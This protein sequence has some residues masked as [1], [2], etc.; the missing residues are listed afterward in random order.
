MAS[1]GTRQCPICFDTVALA[2][3]TEHCNAHFEAQEPQ[4]SVCPV[5]GCSDLPSGELQSHLEAHRL[6]EAE[7]G[8]NISQMRGGMSA[9]PA[10]PQQ[11]RLPPSSPLQ[12][13]PAAFYQMSEDLITL[14][15]QCL[16]HQR[17]GPYTAAV[18]GHVVHYQT[19]PADNGFGCGYR[20]IQMLASHLMKRSQAM[21]GALFGGCGFVPDIA[22]LQALVE[23]AWAAGWDSAGLEQLGRLQG[24][25]TWI[26]TTEA[27]SLFRACGL[28]AEIVDFE[29]GRSQVPVPDAGSSGGPDATS[30]DEVHPGVECDGCG[31]YPIR[32]ACWTGACVDG[33]SYDLCA[34]C[35]SRPAASDKGPF[36]RRQ[37]R[38]QGQENNGPALVK[39]VWQYFTGQQVESEDAMQRLMSN[40]RS[41]VIRSDKPPLFFQHEGHSRTIVGIEL[42]RQPGKQIYNLLV[43]DPGQRSA[44]LE[45]AL[46]SGTGWERMLKVGLHTLRRSEY[47]LLFVRDDLLTAE[48]M[49]DSKLIR[50]SE[51]F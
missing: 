32:G 36:S 27:C 21:R 22:S 2:D 49:E 5:C 20:N 9:T 40:S 4:Q 51:R 24:T 38:K 35:H 43:L 15:L 8:G 44:P 6:Q 11:P 23:D 33:E 50:A 7:I 19:D 42:Q 3:I 48:Q 28:A 17:G 47:Q 18:S 39:W 12:P 1:A 29:G 41:R 26:G 25:R 14:L 45:Q 16:Q 46:R 13:R 30:G 37:G 10:Q 34:R 31:Q